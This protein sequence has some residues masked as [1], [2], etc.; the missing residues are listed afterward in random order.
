MGS[1]LEGKGFTFPLGY[2]SSPPF[3]DIGVKAINYEGNQVREG[4]RHYKKA[5]HPKGQKDV[6]GDHLMGDDDNETM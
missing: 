4:I 3:V 6:T 5:G 1:G 2:G